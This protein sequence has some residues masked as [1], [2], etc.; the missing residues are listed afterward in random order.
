M[1]VEI[2]EPDLS[3]RF[4]ILKRYLMPYGIHDDALV[5]LAKATKG[6]TPALLRQL[7][8]AI[9][10]DMVLAPRL[11]IECSAN[12]VIRRAVASI[13]PHSDQASPPLWGDHM[14][15]AAQITAYWPPTIQP[16]RKTE[17]EN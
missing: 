14:A 7:A 5:V 15:A 13:A 2:A 12:S 11:L 3:C 8:E 10:R 6:A 9:K 17:E 4:A 16:N 1:H